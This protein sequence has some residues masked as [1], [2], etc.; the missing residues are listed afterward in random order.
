MSANISVI[1]ITY[2]SAATIN[3]SLIAL[4]DQTY[5]DFE[6]I[7][8]D[9]NSSDTTGPILN[10]VLPTLSC[11]SRLVPLPQ[12][13]G[14]AAGNNSALEF[15]TGQYIALLNPDAFPD[16]DWLESLIKAVGSDPKIGVCASKII[17]D[18]LDL[19]DSAGDG[20]STILKGYKRGEGAQKTLYGTPEYVFG[21]CAGAALYRRAMI[22]E[23][24]FFDEEYFLVHEDTDLNFRANLTGWKIIYV[25]SAIVR[26]RV[27]SSIG[28]MSDLQI[29]HNLRNA[30]FVRIKNIP[31]PLL[32]K[33][34]LL[35]GLG[36]LAEFYYFAIKHRRPRVFF[37][38]KADALRKFPMMWKKRRIIIG[39][40]RVDNRHLER[41]LTS[42]WRRDF[43]AARLR[44]ILWLA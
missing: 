33:Y 25:P 35:L 12:N 10:T 6:L 7:V 27:H 22:E 24:G 15:A 34:L 1:I 30:E 16:P 38:A 28:K 3:K 2:N 18:D 36:S 32:M 40:R 39:Q 21:A 44:K 5:K 42:I 43:L 29:Y 37:K 19:I 14:F 20:F 17:N 26:H 13:V 4:N 41:M 9:N 11:L 31:T 8:L 23:I